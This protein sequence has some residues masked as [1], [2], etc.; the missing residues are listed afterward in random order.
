MAGKTQRESTGQVGKSRLNDMRR[1]TGKLCK[2]DQ[3]G[4]SVKR[5]NLAECHN[6]VSIYKS[7][8]ILLSVCVSLSAG[9]ILGEDLPHRPLFSSD[10]CG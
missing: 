7:N 3:K 9:A 10:W 1:K 4:V 6:C 2:S 5:K 8:H